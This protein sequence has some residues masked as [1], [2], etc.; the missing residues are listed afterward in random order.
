MATQQ[1]VREEKKQRLL[2]LIR[3]YV[4][5]T[6]WGYVIERSYFDELVVEAEIGTSRVTKSA[7][8][9]AFHAWR[10]LIDT[11]SGKTVVNPEFMEEPGE[12]SSAGCPGATD[13]EVRA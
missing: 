12:K 7:W 10:I 4:E 3:L 9:D 2:K 1:E 5:E 13:Q 8:W 6:R 11:K